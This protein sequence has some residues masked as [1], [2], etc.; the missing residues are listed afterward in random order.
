MIDAKMNTGLSPENFQRLVAGNPPRAG[1]GGIIYTGAVRLSWP[2][3]CKPSVQR[4]QEGKQTP[5]YQASG[6]FPHNNIGVVAEA[7]KAAIRQHYPNITDPS[8]LM[9]PRNKN[10]PLKDQGIKVASKDGGFDIMGK[11]TGGY[12]PGLPFVTAKSTQNVPCMRRVNGRDVMIM[13]EELD[14]VMYAGAWVNM[15]LLLIK[16]SSAGNVG[17]FFG[18]QGIFKLAD[19][20]KFG[21]GA[22]ATAED[23]SGGFTIEDPNAG[24]IVTSTASAGATS[25][26]WG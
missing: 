3:L 24:G 26:P 18:L 11:T 21:G 20:N 7:V 5:K 22:G 13:Q 1:E 23:F 15:K 19:D 2:S 10:H 14:A 17:V 8:I 12:V 9:D 16:S 25:D 4:G 6:L